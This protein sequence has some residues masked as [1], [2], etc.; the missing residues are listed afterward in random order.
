MLSIRRSLHSIVQ[1]QSSIFSPCSK[2]M[3]R[4]YSAMGTRNKLTGDVKMAE[5]KRANTEP[6]RGMREKD[7]DRRKGE[8]SYMGRNGT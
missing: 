5:L 6:H 7:E 8:K 2:G 1:L 3:K 4:T